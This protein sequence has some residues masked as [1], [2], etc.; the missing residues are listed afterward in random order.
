MPYEDHLIAVNKS[1][2]NT[3]VAKIYTMLV[4]GLEVQGR[5]T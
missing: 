1:V 2:C 4:A 3:L 5:N